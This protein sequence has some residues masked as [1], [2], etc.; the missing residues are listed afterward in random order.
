MIIS[1]ITFNTGGVRFG[2]DGIPIDFLDT[3]FTNRDTVDVYVVCLQ[4]SHMSIR[5]ALAKSDGGESL[6]DDILIEARHRY[7][8]DKF[9]R[10]VYHEQ[11]GWGVEMRRGL[12]IAVFAK[13]ATVDFKDVHTTD[14]VPCAFFR[15][16]VTGGKGAIAVHATIGGVPLSFTNAHLPFEA[17]APRQ[18]VQER[19]ECLQKITKKVTKAHPDRVAFLAGD[20]NFRVEAHPGDTWEQLQSFR[21]ERDQL[22]SGHAQR[23]ALPWLEEAPS[24]PPTCRLRTGGDRRWEAKQEHYNLWK[25]DNQQK[26]SARRTPSYCDRILYRCAADTACSVV[27]IRRIDT[28]NMNYSDH[29]AVQNDFRISRSP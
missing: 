9:E 28:G 24:Y 20:L 3:W 4:E 21:P 13:R 25:N 14:F 19:F 10:V 23:L 17:T 26:A 8:L 6:G 27:R 15:D 16:T 2:R 5:Q 1:V 7:L 22:T 18:G 12:R 11:V 29:A